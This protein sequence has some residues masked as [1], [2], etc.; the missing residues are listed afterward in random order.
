MTQREIARLACKVLAV[1]AIIDAFKYLHYSSR[2]IWAL[3]EAWSSFSSSWGGTISS[4]ITILLPF[5][6]IAVGI[7]LWRRAGVVAAWMTGHNLQDEQDEPDVIHVPADLDAVQS[8]VISMMGVWV[9]VDAVPALAGQ[10]AALLPILDTGRSDFDDWANRSAA[11]SLIW[12]ISRLAIGIWLIFGAAG[13]VRMLKRIRYAGLHPEE[14][15][16]AGM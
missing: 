14:R 8:V 4:A 3:F 10:L 5:L 6:Q 12:L 16:P 7:W 11:M 15:P 1:W 13:I 2:Q 9:L